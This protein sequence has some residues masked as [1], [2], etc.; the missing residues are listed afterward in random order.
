MKTLAFLIIETFDPGAVNPHSS[1]KHRR[2][3]DNP[4]DSGGKTR[5]AGPI[6]PPS[7]KESLMKDI[8]STMHDIDA[9]F[10]DEDVE[11][12]EGDVTRSLVDGIISIDFSDRV[13]SLVEKSLDQTLVVKLLGRRIGYTTLR[14]KIYEI[15]KPHQAIWLMDI[16]ND[17]FLVT[18]KLRSVYLKKN[19]P[20][21]YPTLERADPVME[22]GPVNQSEEPPIVLTVTPNQGDGDV[23]SFGPWMIAERHPRRN[24][25]DDLCSSLARSISFGTSIHLFDDIWIPALGSLRPHLH[26]G[27]DIS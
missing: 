22:Q 2:L 17:Y 13:R 23:G 20:D 26:F 9:S 8:E 6:P 18:F 12:Q 3:D 1:R 21:L 16:E 5:P 10:D 25:R 14:T 24:T 27:V 4:P 15:W 19:C 7:Y 11:I